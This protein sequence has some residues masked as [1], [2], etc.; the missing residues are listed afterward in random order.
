MYLFPCVHFG[1]TLCCV[2]QLALYLQQID[3]SMQIRSGCGTGK[4]SPEVAAALT[5]RPGARTKSRTRAWVELH[6]Y[7]S[8]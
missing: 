8:R 4:K 6:F 5:E 1:I 2:E 7:A 3:L